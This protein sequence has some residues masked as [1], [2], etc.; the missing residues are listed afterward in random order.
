MLVIV[1]VAYRYICSLM[2]PVRE[3][4]YCRCSPSMKAG[5]RVDCC[6]LGEP[7]LDFRNRTPR[8]A[9]STWLKKVKHQPKG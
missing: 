2:R 5:L 4:R 6:C 1:G 7:P 9:N 8:L 3:G